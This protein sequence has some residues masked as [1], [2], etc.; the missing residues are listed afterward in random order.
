LQYFVILKKGKKYY[1]AF[2]I[3]DEKRIEN[4]VCRL[5]LGIIFEKKYFA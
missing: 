2:D 3:L 4:I 5:R 1:F